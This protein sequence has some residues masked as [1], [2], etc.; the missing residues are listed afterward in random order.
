MTSGSRRGRGAGPLTAVSPQLP[1]RLRLHLPGAL[2]CHGPR[3]RH[4]PGTVPLRRPLPPQPAPRLSHLL[5][6]QQ[7]T[8]RALM[9]P[10]PSETGL[11]VRAE[12]CRSSGAAGN[13]GQAAADPFVSLSPARSLRTFSSSCAVPRTASTPSLSCGSS[14]TLWP[15][16]SSSSPSTSSWRSAGPGAASSSGEGLE[17]AVHGVLGVSASSAP[18]GGCAWLRGC[19]G[20]RVGSAVV[21]QLPAQPGCVSEDE[22]PALRPWTPLPPP[23]AVWSPGLYP[24][25]LHL[26]PAPGGS[27]FTLAAAAGNS[28]LPFQAAEP[29]VETVVTASVASN[30]KM[31]VK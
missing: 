20:S 5:P 22:H 11:S 31:G 23:S 16:P 25:A 4:P 27:L 17:A 15:W 1:R 7:G 8:L 26:C 28:G 9:S 10:H 2:P 29:W 30:S 19:L 14:M 18:G 24:Q 12:V 3:L 13:P 21:M 6:N